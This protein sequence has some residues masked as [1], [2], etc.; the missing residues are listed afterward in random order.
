MLLRKDFIGYRI[1]ED[2]SAKLTALARSL[3][4]MRGA[5]RAVGVQA[6]LI[7]RRNIPRLSGRLRRSVRTVLRPNMTTVV[8]GGGRILY[9]EV[10]ERGWRGHNIEGTYY[11]RRTSEAM[12]RKAPRTYA[13]E[14]SKLISREGL[15]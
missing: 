2:A 6:T 3:E 10:Q 12:Q 15:R 9:A 7:A 8:V 4:D 11:M 13:E 1:D 5:A 14:L